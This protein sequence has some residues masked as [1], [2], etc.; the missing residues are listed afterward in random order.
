MK[1]KNKKNKN[2]LDRKKRDIIVFFL[3]KIQ[4]IFSDGYVNRRLEN[5]E[6]SS[7]F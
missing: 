4:N 7:F 2:I 1:N 6:L 5:I 3:S